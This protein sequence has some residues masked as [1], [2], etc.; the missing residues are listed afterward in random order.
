MIIVNLNMAL[1]LTT[2]NNIKFCYTDQH[3]DKPLKFVADGTIIVY[4]YV[5]R[6]PL[7]KTVRSIRARGEAGTLFPVIVA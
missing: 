1:K 5:A 4:R 7:K 3:F 2:L 6:V